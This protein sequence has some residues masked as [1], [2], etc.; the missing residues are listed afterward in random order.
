MRKISASAAPIHTSAERSNPDATPAGRLTAALPEGRPS[1]PE[2]LHEALLDLLVAL[3][4]L[5][6]I[7]AQQL[8]VGELRLVGRILHLRVARVEPLG[9]GHHLLDLAAKTEVGEQLGRVGMRRR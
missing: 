5:L 8:E 6:G 4:E 7:N 3:L 1:R 2:E 9:V